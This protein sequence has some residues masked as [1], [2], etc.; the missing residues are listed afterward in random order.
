[1]W[2]WLPEEGVQ[3]AL[4][5]DYALTANPS[6]ATLTAHELLRFFES[7]CGVS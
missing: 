3:R 4:Y 5:P 1:V 2:Y 6:I 7:S